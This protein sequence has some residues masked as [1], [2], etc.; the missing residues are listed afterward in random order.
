MRFIL[1]NLY[2]ALTPHTGALLR[3]QQMQAPI[4]HT[5]FTKCIVS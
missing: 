2:R 4:M 3:Q 1:L 5:R